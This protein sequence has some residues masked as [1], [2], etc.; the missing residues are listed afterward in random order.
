VVI[1][2]KSHAS[3]ASRPAV[4]ETRPT[5]GWTLVALLEMGAPHHRLR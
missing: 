5:K 3:G 1:D 4:I 2:V